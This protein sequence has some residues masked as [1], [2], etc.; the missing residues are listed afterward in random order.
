MGG[1][2]SPTRGAAL[3]RL[4]PAR[5]PTEENATVLV[6]HID[7]L[8]ATVWVSVYDSGVCSMFD[9]T[10]VHITYSQPSIGAIAKAERMHARRVTL[11]KLRWKKQGQMEDEW[12]ELQLNVPRPSPVLLF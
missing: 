5:G 8:L 11:L 4:L 2:S 10:C 1:S 12:P 6:S 3:S 7:E 9:R